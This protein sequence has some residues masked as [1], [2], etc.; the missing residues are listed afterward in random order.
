MN[1]LKSLIQKLTI[2]IP[3]AV[4]MFTE[5]NMDVFSG[6]ATLFIL[7][8]VFPCIM[9]IISIVNLLP[10]YSADDVVLVLFQLLPDLEPIKNLIGSLMTDLQ[11]QSGGLL[12]SAAAVTTLWA[13]SNGVSAI[14]KG[15]NQLEPKEDEEESGAKK[16]KDEEIEEIKDKSKSLIT[17]ILKRLAFTLMVVILIP[18]MLVFDMLGNSIANIIFDVLEKLNPEGAGI[19]LADIGSIFHISSLAVLVFALL[20]IL[21]I[22][23]ILP[24]KRRTLKSQL[25]GAIVTGASWLIFTRFFSFFIPRFYHA[26]KFYGS[27][28]SL[29]LVV[30]WLRYMVMILFIGGVLNRTLEEMD[31]SIIPSSQSQSS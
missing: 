7:S 12:A 22:Y 6:Y 18:A 13:A 15:L 17:E 2:V 3:R 31:Q 29:F 14:Q 8:A 25:P 5:N 26:S 23:A 19:S 10:G 16:K 9:L 20:V 1:K 24:E 11:N 27:L 4:E 28:A 30:L 21:Q